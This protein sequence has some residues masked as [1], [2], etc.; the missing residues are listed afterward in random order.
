M[1]VDAGYAALH[2]LPEGTLETTRSEWRARTHPDDLARV[3]DMRQQAFRE[4]L[5]EYGVEYR[6][7]RTGGEVH[8]IES[9]SFIAHTS[10]GR[11]QRIAGVNI[12]ITE[13]KRAEEHLRTLVAELDHR[14]KNVLA[15]VSSVTSRTQEA[16]G[17][18]AD[19]IAALDG[20]IK[21]MAATH[22]LLSQHQWKGILLSDLVRRELAP[23]AAN[24][25][26]EI[27]GPDVTLKAEAAQSLSMVL[28]ELTT[29]A[30]KYGAFSIDR[31]RVSVRWHWAL[32]GEADPPLRIEWQESGGPAVQAPDRSGYGME[33]I[34]DL[35]PYELDGK[36]DLA[37]PAEGVRC[38]F[39]IPV[40]QLSNG[41]DQAHVFPT[42]HPPPEMGRALRQ[43][44][45]SCH[46]AHRPP[47]L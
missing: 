27:G 39:D 3:E 43:D 13:R 32:N 41:D 7:A 24:G 31:G 10:D 19:F 21:S 44:A 15:T 40:S 34:R 38:R 2:G 26:T 29:N 1:Q 42:P 17:S 11:P 20:R 23:Y 46:G 36:V 47:V 35:L 4:R 18:P 8:W 14:V 5:G 33:V 16:S 12:D 6:I 37:F 45:E 25:N 9:R 30:A 22:Q 28:H